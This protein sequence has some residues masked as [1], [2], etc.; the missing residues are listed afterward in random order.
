MNVAAPQLLHILLLDTMDS[1]QRSSLLV[2]IRRQ[3]VVNVIL[4][5]DPRSS[6]LRAWF[7]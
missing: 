1:P 3:L 5:Y 6:D 4:H 7:W 2:R